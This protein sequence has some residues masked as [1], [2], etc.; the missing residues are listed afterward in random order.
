MELR[1]WSLVL[2]LE[3]LFVNNPFTL[4]LQ[5]MQLLL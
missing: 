4:L 3:D 5:Q 2:K 1:R